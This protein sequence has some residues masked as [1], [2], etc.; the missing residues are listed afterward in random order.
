MG[1]TSSFRQAWLGGALALVIGVSSSAGAT[2]TTAARSLNEQ[3]I[4]IVPGCIVDAVDIIAWWRGNGNVAATIGPDLTGSVAFAPGIIGQGMQLDNGDVLS[5]DAFPEVSTGLT[6]EAWIQPND[7]GGVQTIFSRWD[8]P[9]TDDSARSYALFLE[10]GG[11]LVWST[12]E[13]STR[14]PEEASTIVPLLFDGDFHHVAATWTSTTLAIY[15]D[16]TAILTVPSQGGVLN[17]ASSTQF[18]LGSK[19]G[20]GDPFF[21]D[22]IID[23]PAVIGR[24]L[25]ATEVSD[26]VDAGPNGKCAPV[27]GPTLTPGPSGAATGASARW[28]GANTGGEIF[29]G[30]MLPPAALPRSES[31]HLWTPGPGFDVT[32]V[33]DATENTLT[34]TATGATTSSVLYDF[35][36]QGAPGCA[37]AN[38]DVLDLLVVDGRADAGLRVS[39]LT[40]GGAPLGD[41]GQIDIAGTPGAQAWSVTGV[42]FSQSFTATATIEVGGAGFVGNE[43]MRFQATTGCLAP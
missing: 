4:V 11:R 5:V 8:F 28:K 25:S 36:T 9:S 42:D 21:F 24:A 39:D 26:L 40:V 22:G 15:V 30:P 32:M 33:F 23:E 19:S 3:I 2:I 38:W 18:R 35:D 41:L 34:G 17:P 43:G 13:T 16:G 12:D 7:T 31:N 27:T 10:P 1:R 20:L 14:R 37:S 29:V 6:V